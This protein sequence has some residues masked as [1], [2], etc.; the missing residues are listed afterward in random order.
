MAR[1]HRP[2]EIQRRRHRK[3]K[4]HRLRERFRKARSGE[5]RRRI[6][7]KAQGLSPLLTE[8]QLHRKTQAP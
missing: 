2:S 6:L 1:G 4:L 8:E 7:Q 5:E 3:K